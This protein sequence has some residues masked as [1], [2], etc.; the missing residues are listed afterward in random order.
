MEETE[1][2]AKIQYEGLV[3]RIMIVLQIR[4]G[5]LF[6][7]TLLYHCT[8]TLTPHNGLYCAPYC[9]YPPNSTNDYACFLTSQHASHTHILHEEVG[10]T[11]MYNMW[12]KSCNSQLLRTRSTPTWENKAWLPCQPMTHM[13][14]HAGCFMVFLLVHQSRHDRLSLHAD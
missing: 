10:M 4:N 1:E 3:I 13:P 5:N 6:F 12:K 8:E 9:M 2:K 14:I 11:Y 7:C